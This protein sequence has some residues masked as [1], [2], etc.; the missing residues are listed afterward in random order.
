MVR[1]DSVALS[2]HGAIQTA[3]PGLKP[4]ADIQRS[5]RSAKELHVCICACALRDTVMAPQ[6]KTEF[7]RAILQIEIHVE[8]VRVRPE[9]KSVVFFHFQLNPVADEILREDV[10]FEQE[11]VIRFDGGNRAS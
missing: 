7:A 10:A 8:L 3:H 1:A 2:G 5:C 4:W 11:I 6:P 9:P